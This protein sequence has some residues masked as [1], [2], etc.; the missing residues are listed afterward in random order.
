MIG[1]TM[2]ESSAAVAAIASVSMGYSASHLVAQMFLICAANCQLAWP[3]NT[4]RSHSH[5]HSHAT[6]IFSFSFS[7]GFAFAFAFRGA[8]CGVFCAS[9]VRVA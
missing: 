6:I 2:K 4:S 8:T 9:F 3:I 7:F 1:E 5:S